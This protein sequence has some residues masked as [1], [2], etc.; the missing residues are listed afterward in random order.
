MRQARVALV[1]FVACSRTELDADRA[2]VDA[3][4]ATDVVD[5]SGPETIEEGP[6]TPRVLVDKVEPGGMVLDGDY[7]YFGGGAPFYAIGRVPKH[8]GGVQELSNPASDSIAIDDTYVYWTLTLGSESGVVRRV[9]KAG[10]TTDIFSS[11]TGTATGIAVDGAAVYVGDGAII[12]KIRK[13]DGA[14]IQELG[15]FKQIMALAVVGSEVYVADWQ[16]GLNRIGT[17]GSNPSSVHPGSSS[18]YLA[19]IDGFVL[20]QDNAG[21]WLDDLVQSAITQVWT[22]VAYGITADSMNV[23]WSA[24]TAIMRAAKSGGTPAVV[25]QGQFYA[26]ELAVDDTCVF[27]TSEYDPGMIAQF[28]K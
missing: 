3:A 25:T 26:R 23:Y 5:A 13:S 2:S 12:H 24:D 14:Q 28:P 27:Y 9:P 4:P 21:A 17:D 11:W 7:V 1:L 10:G 22:G 20:W 6:C 8:G 18:R 15:S 16:T 19:T